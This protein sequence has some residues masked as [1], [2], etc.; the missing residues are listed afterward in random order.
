MSFAGSATSFTCRRLAYKTA[1]HKTSNKATHSYQRPTRSARSS[2]RASSSIPFSGKQSVSI[3]TRSTSS[4]KWVTITGRIVWRALRTQMDRLR[5]ITSATL[6]IKELKTMRHSAT[7]P[8]MIY[9]WSFK[10]ASSPWQSLI[11]MYSKSGTIMSPSP[12]DQ[13]IKI[14]P[15]YSHPQNQK[16]VYYPFSPFLKVDN[17]QSVP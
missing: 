2:Q 11:L 6:C 4:T 16:K 5:L 3:P 17:N 12:L 8:S 10:I 7:I 13:T 1:I 14:S 15:L 9:W